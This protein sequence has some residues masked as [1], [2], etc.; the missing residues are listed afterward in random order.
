MTPYIVSF[1]L[2]SYIFGVSFG[3]FL[4][5]GT[6]TGE[7][8]VNHTKYMLELFIRDFYIHFI[9]HPIKVICGIDTESIHEAYL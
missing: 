5:T 2:F 4:C 8:S 3:I 9:N 7:F 6:S 1:Y